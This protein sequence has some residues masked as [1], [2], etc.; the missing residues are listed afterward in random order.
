MAENNQKGKAHNLNRSA[1]NRAS[2]KKKNHVAVTLANKKW[3]IE[4]NLLQ[5]DPLA[6]VK[7]P[8]SYQRKKTKGNN[9]AFGCTSHIPIPHYDKHDNIQGF[10]C[11]KCK[12]E[13]K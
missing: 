10:T 6:G 1:K 11:Q 13:C 3:N 12:Q 7:G 4:T 8:R 2:G 9:G 5:G